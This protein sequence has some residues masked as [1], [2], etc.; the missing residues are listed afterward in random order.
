MGKPNRLLYSSTLAIIL[1]LGA[2]GGQTSRTLAP[3]STIPPTD[4]PASAIYLPLV[5]LAGQSPTFVPTA[6][7]PGSTITPTVTARSTLTPSATPMPTSLCGPRSVPTCTVTPSPTATPTT[8]ATFTVTLTPTSTLIAPDNLA[9]EQALAEL[10]NQQRANNGA[11]ALTLEDAITQ[12]ARR[13]SNDM[14]DH[15]F[16]GHTGSDGSNGGRRM[17]IAG[18]DWVTWGEIVAWGFPDAAS[19]LDWWMNSPPHRAN[20]LATRFV[21]FGVSY[22]R[23]NN[24]TYTHYW[25][26]DFGKPATAASQMTAAQPLYRCTY[27]QEDGTRGSSITIYSATPCE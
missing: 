24:S 17:Q 13:H 10:I 15:N 18:Y 3:A 8:T 14:A 27:T 26:I 20:I 11:A 5:A 7:V 2:L 22:A 19:A 23:N 25:T 4:T 1:W 6:P 21:D 12:A 16:T 9:F